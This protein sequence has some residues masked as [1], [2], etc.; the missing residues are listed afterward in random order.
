[1]SFKL[2]FSACG[3]DPWEQGEF[4]DLKMQNH[5]WHL[6]PISHYTFNHV[7][8]LL[9][10]EFHWLQRPLQGVWSVQKGQLL[11]LKLMGRRPWKRLAQLCQRI[12]DS[13]QLHN[14]LKRSSRVV[15]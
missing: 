4:L 6:R 13:K 7:A 3:K 11:T 9:D 2:S 14:C 10:M 12:L 15:S 5:L 8:G 1:M